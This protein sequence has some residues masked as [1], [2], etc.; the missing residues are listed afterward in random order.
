MPITAIIF[1]YGCVLS[2]APGP[3]DYEPLRKAIGA[4]AAAFQEIYWRNR[5][6]YDRDALDTSSYWQQV[7]HAA[8]AAFSSQL[9]QQWATLDCEIWGKPN[10]VMVEWAQVLRRQGLKLAILSNMSRYVGDYLR[11]TV[12]WLAL[13]DHLCFSGELKVMKPDPAIYRVCLRS[14]GVPAAQSLF[15]DDR[16]VNVTAARAVGMHGIVF[17]SAEE[18]QADLEPYGLAASLAEARARV[19]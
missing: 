17:R 6:E 9:L 13:F 4:E 16:E 12:K 15:I 7:G 1:D 3:E 14:L 2:L 8:G 18:L 11:R 19:G 10:S 5:D